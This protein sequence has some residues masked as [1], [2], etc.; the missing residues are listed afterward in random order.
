MPIYEYRCQ[1]CRSL[2]EIITSTCQLPTEIK[3]NN[4]GSQ[5]TEKTI[6]A[7]SYRL[8]SRSRSAVPAGALTGCASKSGFS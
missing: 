8:A 3:C 6:S 1:D 7:A 4:C 5:R 2:F